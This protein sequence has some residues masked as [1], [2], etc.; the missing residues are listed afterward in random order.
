[1]TLKFTPIKDLVA[2]PPPRRTV[3][4]RNLA[5]RWAWYLG[6]IPCDRMESCQLDKHW[7]CPNCG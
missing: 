3:Q 5:L 7:R 2:T 1:M 4:A 6:N